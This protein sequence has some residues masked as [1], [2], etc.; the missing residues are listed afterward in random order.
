MCH[1]ICQPY[2]KSRS[3]RFT[4]CRV[5]TGGCFRPKTGLF[6]KRCW[7]GESF[8]DQFEFAL[9]HDELDLLVL[10]RLF[11]AVPQDI[12]AAFARSAPTGMS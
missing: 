10:K 8:G 11:E 7:P 9:R 4:G 12:V 3:S 1:S 2:R 6:D 5:R